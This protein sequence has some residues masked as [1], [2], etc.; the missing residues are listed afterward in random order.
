[1]SKII[2]KEYID[3]LI[4]IWLDQAQSIEQGWP[5]SSTLSRFAEYRGSFQA[6]KIVSGLEIY[7]DRQHK[8]D[9]RFADIDVALGELE[10]KRALIIISKRLYQGLN[11]ANKAYTNS[12]RAKIVGLGLRQYENNLAAAYRDIEKTLILLKKREQYTTYP[13]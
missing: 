10:E 1:M 5:S 6:S 9:A 3:D 2:N 11:E 13:Q 8:R 7:V 12:D 4:N